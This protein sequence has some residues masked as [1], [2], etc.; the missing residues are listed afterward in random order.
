MARTKKT[1]KIIAPSE[2]GQRIVRRKPAD[3][4]DEPESPSDLPE[5]LPIL[6]LRNLVLFPG[7]VAPLKV[8]RAKSRQLL[9]SQLPESNVV[10]CLCQRSPGTEDPGPDDLYQLGVATAVLKLLKEGEDEQT[11]VVHGS[12]R[13]RVV[14]WVQTGPFLKARFEPVPD[15]YEPSKEIDALM[16]TTRQQASRLIELSPNVPDEADLVLSSIEHPGQLADFLA[17]N[18]QLDVDVKQKLLAEADVNQRLRQVDIELQR[19]IEILELSAK[20][21]DQVREKIDKT[22]RQYYLE[23]QLKA[24]QKELGQGDERT[25]EIDRLRECIES[26]GMP[27]QVRE[28]TVREV[29]RLAQ[30]PQ[31]SP[32][33]NMVRTYLDVMCELPWDRSAQGLIDVPKARKILDQDHYDLEKV[34]RRILEYLAVRKLAPQSRGPILCFAG[35]PGVGKTSLGKSIARALGRKF[36]RMSLGGIRDEA[37]LRGHRRTYVGAMPGRIIQ[38]IRKAGENNPVFMLDELDKVGQDFRGD[39]TSVLLEV[40]DPA[41]NDSFQDHYLNAP[42]DLSQVLFIATANYMQPVPA[43]LR[44]RMETIELP[45][46]TRREKLHIATKYLVPRQLEQNGLTPSKLT[47]RDEGLLKI[48]D[49]YTREAG[50]RD[51]ERQIGSVARAVAALIAEGKAR[52]RTANARLVEEILGPARFESELAQRTGVPGVATGLAYTPVG[53]EVLFVEAAGYPG[54][55]QLQLTGQIGDVMRESALAAMSLIKSRADEL[56]ISSDDLSRSDIH[57]H[58]PAGAIPK[59]GPSAGVAMYSALVSL[60]TNRAIRPDVAMT[61]EITLRGLV[62]PVGGVKEKVLAARR[63]GIETVVLPRRNQKDLADVPEDAKK[64]LSF[65]FAEKVADVLDVAWDSPPGGKK[66]SAKRSARKRKR[67][68]ASA[69]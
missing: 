61:G 40:L 68:G 30:I 60:L 34:K 47:F 15:I 1:K 41:Q 58:V 14:E 62:M 25:A 32:E 66:R 31:A 8:G 10:A 19:Q 56:G 16:H 2:E 49:S 33:Y 45:G 3:R 51:L 43:P 53:G 38:E 21:Q 17:A 67:A 44:D 26:A 6:P 69:K 52:S 35:P 7:T 64:E 55:G 46:Y 42:F 22:Q 20:I 12:Q 39:P 48:I 37:E 4:P 65:V 23:E 11:A 13:I 63:A 5:V 54:K 18:L 9:E 29:E 36:I 27:E 59:D 57:I 50:V 24:I 28:E